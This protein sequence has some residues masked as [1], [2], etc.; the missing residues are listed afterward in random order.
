MSVK[1]W[2]FCASDMRLGY[3]DGRE[4]RD[5]EWIEV[6]AKPVLCE[7]GLHASLRILDALQYSPPRPCLCRVEVDGDVVH[8]DDKMVGRRR[9][10]LWHL[11]ADTTDRVLRSFACRTALE[12]LPPDATPVIREYLTTVD[13]SKREAAD[14]AAYRAAERK[15]QNRRLAAMAAA[16]RRAGR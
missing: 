5:G 4:I 8:G 7:A 3:G 9:R 12:I 16:A 1:G 2:H 6:D 15:R 10:V 14:R 11:D 13:E